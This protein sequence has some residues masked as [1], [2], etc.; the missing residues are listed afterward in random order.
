MGR[1]ACNWV[2]FLKVSPLQNRDVNVVGQR[3]G[4][5]GEVVFEVVREIPFGG[6]LVTFLVP[7]LGVP[8]DSLLLPALQIIRS[9]LYRRTI[10]NIMADAPLDLSRSLLTASSASSRV[11]AALSPRRATSS[12]VEDAS[13]CSPSPPS[14]ASL[15]PPHTG[16]GF[17]PTPRPLGLTPSPTNP[18]LGHHDLR[19]SSMPT[20]LSSRYVDGYRFNIKVEGCVGSI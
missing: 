12:D 1:R 8:E 10:D 18:L 15:S 2:R 7:D 20:I 3:F 16:G 5:G 17:L 4:P 13:S 14:V 11:E 6:E 19:F 9:S